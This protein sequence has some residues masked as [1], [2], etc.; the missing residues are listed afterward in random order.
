M[1]KREMISRELEHLP[2]QDLDSLLA[3]LQRLNEAHADRTLSTLAAE[4]SLAKDW[5]GAEEDAAWADL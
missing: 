5:L 2:E 4:T 1:S 3:F